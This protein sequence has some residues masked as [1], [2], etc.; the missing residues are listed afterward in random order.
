MQIS[1]LGG[2]L[3]LWGILLEM[4]VMSSF[5]FVVVL[6]CFVMHRKSAGNRKLFI[7][8]SASADR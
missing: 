7:F 5:G 3:V 8:R 2:A 4:P 1:V 6:A